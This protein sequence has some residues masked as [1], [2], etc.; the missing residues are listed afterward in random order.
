MI[1]LLTL[2]LIFVFDPNRLCHAIKGSVSTHYW[3]RGDVC[4]KQTDLHCKVS[5]GSHTEHNVWERLE[6]VLCKQQTGEGSAG[7]VLLG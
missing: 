4:G 6:D 7:V 1:P 5:H 2:I 3:R